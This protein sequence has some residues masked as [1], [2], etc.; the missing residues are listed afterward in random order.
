MSKE[1]IYWPLGL[2]KSVT[3]TEKALVHKIK[4]VCRL[5]ISQSLY[6]FD[7]KGEEVRYFIEKVSKGAVVLTKDKSIC[8]QALPKKRIYLGFPLTREERVDFILQKCVELGVS[9]FIPFISERS[10]SKFPSANRIRRWQKIIA[11]ATRQSGRLWLPIIEQTVKFNDLI[12]RPYA[13]KIAGS[14]EGKIIKQDISPALGEVL[15]VV[16]PEGDFSPQEYEALAK[17]GF[18]FIKLACV[19]LRVETAAVFAAGLVNYF[20]I[21]R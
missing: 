16:G 13:L 3:I 14:I 5:R 7:G 12:S 10:I 4:D 20:T 1:R 17:S 6:L 18:Q 21:S 2:D 19:I 15:I 8:R 9:G 11:E